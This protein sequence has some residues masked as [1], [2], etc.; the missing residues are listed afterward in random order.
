MRRIIAIAVVVLAPVLASAPAGAAGG[1]ESF[2]D[3]SAPSIENDVATPTYDGGPITFAALTEF[4]GDPLQIIVWPNDTRRYSLGTDQIGVYVCTWPT[5][6]AG[7]NLTSATSVLNNQVVPF[8]E[9]ISN[10]AYTPQFIARKTLTLDDAQ[11]V[12][13]DCENAMLAQANPLWGDEGAIGILDNKGN[14]G[15]GTPGMYCYN[16]ASQADTTFPANGRWAVVEGETVQSFWAGYGAHVTTAAH[17][18]GHMISFPHSY[19]GEVL[20][21]SN[22]NTYIDEYDNP[23]DFMSGNDPASLIGRRVEYPYSTLAFN[24]Y[25][26]GWIDPSDVVFYSGGVVDLTV[27]PVGVD[28]IQMVILPTGYPYS[29]VTLDARISSDIDRIPESFQ[30]ITS[31]YVEQWWRD[32]ADDVVKPLGGATSRVYTYPPSPY[33]LDHVTSVGEQLQ[34]DL[35][36]GEDVI[37]QGAMLKVLGQTADG[38][39][40]RLIGFDDVATSVFLNNILWLADSGITKGC[41]DTSFCPTEYVTRGQMAAFLVRALGYSDAGTGNLFTDDDGSVFEGSIDR[42]ATAGVTKGCNPPVNDEFCPNQ[43][44]TREQMAAFLV[45]ALGLTEEDPGV[46]FNDIAGSVFVD[47]I[48]K[49][50]TAGITKGCNPPANDRF[51]PRDPVTREQM[52]AFLQRALDG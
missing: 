23:I 19:S 39:Q 28:G 14:E 8:Y 12:W 42:L 32:P 45:R 50:A 43:Y 41:S 13:S 24:R 30:G 9:G 27:A 33:S 10:G 16:C 51:C 29:L 52:A 6:S 5:A 44:V 37:A 31:H 1:P 22:G 15:Q 18:V 49:L 38:L 40:I 48:N 26:A 35:D 11:S 3:G 34:F 20:T 36:Q 2:A 4:S 17:E 47:A 21:D 7:I 46:E 25:R